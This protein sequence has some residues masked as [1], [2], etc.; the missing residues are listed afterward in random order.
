MPD[1]LVFS[2]SL[3]KCHLKDYPDKPVLLCH[4]LYLVHQLLFAPLFFI[5]YHVLTYYRIYSCL[6]LC[7]VAQ[8][9]PTLWNPTN[10]SLPGSSVH[11]ILQARILEWVAISSSR[12]SS[13]PRNWTH[14]SFVFYTGRHILYHC[15]TWGAPQDLLTFAYSIFPARI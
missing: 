1:S 9:W 3:F 5:L 7:S 2:M 11:G 10:C 6:P 14:V 8:S 15:T 12:W 4:P 13:R